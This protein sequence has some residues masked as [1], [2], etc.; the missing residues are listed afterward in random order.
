MSSTQTR[1]N[2]VRALLHKSS[3]IPISESCAMRAKS[4]LNTMLNTCSNRGNMNQFDKQPSSSGVML[5]MRMMSRTWTS[6]RSLAALFV[7]CLRLNSIIRIIHRVAHQCRIRIITVH[8]TT[9]MMSV[10]LQ[11]RSG[12]DILVLHDQSTHHHHNTRN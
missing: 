4:M 9:A 10:R 5:L 11:L 3:G 12:R 8:T 7:F 6:V 2:S 1:D